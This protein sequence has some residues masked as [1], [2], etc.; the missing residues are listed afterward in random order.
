VR[1]TRLPGIP[2]AAVWAGFPVLLTQGLRVRRTTLRL[3]EASGTTG[4][5]GGDG[6]ALRLVVLG[7]SVAAGV[8]VARHDDTMAGQLARRLAASRGRPVGWTV[9]AR[10]G[11]TAG[12]AAALVDADVLASSDVVLVS[13]GVNDTKNLHSDARWRRELGRVLDAVLVAAPAA[14]VIVI[15]IPPMEMFPALP[16]PLS[17]LLGARSRRLDRIGREVAAARARVRR[18]EPAVVEG[19]GFFAEDGFHPSA[20][21]H[22]HLAEGAVRLLP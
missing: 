18:L 9:L 15:G 5:V 12:E 21:L 14:D 10:G 17:L 8:G 3:A 13:I 11:V 22:G 6:E 2:L 19:D 7:D 4:S 16:R 20:V 1:A